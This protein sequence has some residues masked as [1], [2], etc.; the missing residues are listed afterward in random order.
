MNKVLKRV[1]GTD[2]VNKIK[3]PWHEDGLVINLSNNHPEEMEKIINSNLKYPIILH[4][5][6]LVDGHHRLLKSVLLHKRVISVVYI[7]N[8]QLLRCRIKDFIDH[9]EYIQRF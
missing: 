9:D 6:W 2:D 4:D 5:E 1:F 7:S 8:A 3:S